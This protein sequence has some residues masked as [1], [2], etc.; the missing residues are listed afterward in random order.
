MKMAPDLRSPSVFYRDGRR[1]VLQAGEK[2][3]ELRCH[4]E[5][6][7]VVQRRDAESALDRLRGLFNR[8]LARVEAV[9]MAGDDA[10]KL[11]RA[12]A[13][14]AVALEELRDGLTGMENRQMAA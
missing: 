14:A 10:D 5:R 12:V 6:L 7:P 4:A 1:L 13:G 8:A 3:D 2:L 9:R 11:K